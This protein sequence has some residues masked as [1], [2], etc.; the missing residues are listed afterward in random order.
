MP[1]GVCGVAWRQISVDFGVMKFGAFGPDFRGEAG[2][3]FQQVFCWISSGKVG[4]W[5]CWSWKVLAGMGEG[6]LGGKVRGLGRLVSG[7]GRTA[8]GMRLR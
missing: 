8:A 1:L 7:A 6:V 2:R 5:W 4:F 3:E